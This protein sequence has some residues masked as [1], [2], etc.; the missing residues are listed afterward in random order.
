[1]RTKGPRTHGLPLARAQIG[2]SLVEVMVALT[3]GLFVVGGAAAI[4]LAN[5]NS[6]ATVENVAR[7][8]E[9]ARFAAELLA[10][11]IREAG[12][13]PCGGAMTTAN[14]VSSTASRNWAGWDRGLLGNP[15]AAT[16]S[17]AATVAR[18]PV[19]STAAQVTSPATN[20]PPNMTQAV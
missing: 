9:N 19:G 14:L 6:F 16:G 11:D 1:M 18:P 20:L 17:L 13:S 4:Y 5:R 12:N 7:V 3:M 15:M 10:R 8:E 2:V